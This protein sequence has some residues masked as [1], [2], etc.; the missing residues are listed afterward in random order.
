MNAI[1]DAIIV[2]WGWRRLA[3]AILA[4]AASALALAP[5]DLWPICFV[6][7]P[8]FVWLLDGAAPRPGAG[9]FRRLLPAALVGWGFG[10]GFFLAGLWWIGTALLVDAATFGWLLP[11]AVVG[12]PA[13]LA[14]FWAFGAAAARLFWSDA[15]DR[16]LVFAVAM[17]A[18]E[19]LRG[20][21]FTGFPWNAFGYT[22]LPGPL[23][24]QSAALVGLWGIT[25]AAFL[26][27]AAP[28]LAAGAGRG[29]GVALATI[30][31][32]LAA[33]ATFGL[34]RLA[35]AEPVAVEGVRIRIVQPAIDQSRKWDPAA[36]DAIFR[37]YLRLSDSRASPERE[38]VADV[39]H[40]IWPES[41]LPFLLTEEPGA[42]TAIADLLPPGATLITG[43]ARAEPLLPGETAR[44][45]FNSI[46][47]VDDEGG[48]AAAYDKVH[49]VPFGEYLPLK[50]I[51]EAL[52]IN[53]LVQTPG[54][55]S[56]GPRRA[57]IAVDGTPAFG[58]LICYEIIFPGEVLAEGARPGW[59]LNVTNDGWY[60]DTPGPHQHLRQAVVRAVEEGLPLVRAA[61]T[62]VSAI[63]D[64]YGRL[65]TSLGVGPAGVIDGTLPVGLAGTPYG[66]FG[67]RIPA[68]LMIF[69]GAIVVIRRFTLTKAS[70]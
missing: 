20:H 68:A 39:T 3:L 59:L 65:Q 52:G 10:F 18:A 38:G 47:V 16:V 26:I 70:R 31:L 58:P 42:L 66:R 48:I 4:G 24:M 9:I 49:L 21:L 50:K 12:F 67:D 54:G 19:W 51:L 25:L 35:G 36:A 7:I 55:F 53:A 56:P 27:F 2:L 69:L 40:L 43:A 41:A 63:V 15:W 45:V 8:V 60:G 29:R 5:F 11:V 14:L 32:L 33:D 30:L 46:Y 64:A 34:I 44:R 13:A 22:L 17:T 37:G 6:T 57:T 28:V 1:A 23:L 61:N 62:G